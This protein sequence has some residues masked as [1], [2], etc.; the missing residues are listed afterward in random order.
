MKLTISQIC[1]ATVLCLPSLGRAQGQP[2]YFVQVVNMQ[3]MAAAGVPVPAGTPDQ[4]EIFVAPEPGTTEYCASVSYSSSAG[5]RT[6]SGCAEAPASGWTLI[7]FQV[8]SVA[9]I[10]IT[11]VSIRGL[12][13][14]FSYNDPQPGPR[15]LAH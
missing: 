6:V 14:M 11:S 10:E 2:A 7:C 4:I 5:S 1:L 15:V 12:V 3:A 8:P 13:D 9:G